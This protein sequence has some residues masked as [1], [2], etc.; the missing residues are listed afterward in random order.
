[1]ALQ[2]WRDP[3]QLGG[4][5]LCVVSI[6]M[7][8]LA[9]VLRFVANRKTSRSIGVETWLAFVALIFFLVYTSMFLYLLTVMNGASLL[10]LEMGPPAMIVHILKVGD[11]S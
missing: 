7:C 9:T 2:V 6:P 5:I 1:M 11:A 8:I 4:F 10:E 3:Q